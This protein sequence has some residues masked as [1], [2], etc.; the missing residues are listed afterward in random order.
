MIDKEIQE[1]AERYTSGE[2][3]LLSELR[4]LTYS[5]RDDSNMLSGFYQGRLLS[6]ISRT[7]GPKLIL[8]V[9]T[10]MGYSAIC[11]A[12]GLLPGGRLV[13][14][15]VNEETNLIARDFWSRAGLDEVIEPHL[16]EAAGIIPGIE[17]E[18]DLVFID[19]DK[20]NYSNYFDL[21]FPRMRVGGLI[22]ADNV[23]WSGDV[24][25]AEAGSEVKASTRALHEYNVKTASDKRVTNILLGVRD[26]LMISRKEH[27]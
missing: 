9:G 15:D 6:F 18:I 26:G 10:Y 23:L 2:S 25:N 13:T 21:V 5:D 14:I 16:G 4:E 20:E 8:E 19:A 24:L 12:E 22:I 7:L 27:D 17:G 11:L 3:A 1:Y